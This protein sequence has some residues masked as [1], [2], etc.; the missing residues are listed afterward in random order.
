[1]Q[2]IDELQTE[3]NDERTRSEALED[4][5]LKLVDMVKAERKKAQE[6]EQ[7]LS[8]VSGSH[9]QEKEEELEREKTGLERQLLEMRRRIEELEE[10]LSDKE[11]TKQQQKSANSDQVDQLQGQVKELQGKVDQMQTML[12]RQQAQLENSKEVI[13]NQKDELGTARINSDQL[14]SELSRLLFAFLFPNVLFLCC[15]RQ[16][17]EKKD[18]Q[19]QLDKLKSEF[20]NIKL[21]LKSSNGKSIQI[22]HII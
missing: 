8:E 15:N 3:L 1:M 22:I 16:T 9:N 4:K 7:Q 17:E 20:S 12:D 6:A 21:E 14:S 11:D 2:T 5:V 19:T 18:V 13:Q 10:Q